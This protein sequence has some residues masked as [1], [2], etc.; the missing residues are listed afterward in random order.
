MPKITQ[1][2]T[3]LVQVKQTALG[4]SKNTKAM[5][6][7]VTFADVVNGDT[8]TTYLPC[9]KKAWPY[10]E[11]KL[12]NCGWDAAANGYRFEELNADPSPIAGNDVEIVVDLEEYNGKPD[13]RVKFINVPGAGPKRMD[14][15]EAGSFADRLRRQ[16]GVS[17]APTTARSLPREA[18]PANGKSDDIPF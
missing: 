5:Q 15:A 17:G 12:R 4:E 14:D 1:P 16:L 9:S 6:I 18:R 3:Y 7:A 11:E 2:G 13:A 10:T 8:I